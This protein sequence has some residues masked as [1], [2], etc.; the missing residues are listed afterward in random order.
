[1]LLYQ[2]KTAGDRTLVE[3]LSGV[4][5]LGDPR[6]EGDNPPIF[7]LIVDLDRFAA[8][9]AVLDVALGTGRQ[10]EQHGDHLAAVGAGEPFTGHDPLAAR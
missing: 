10:I 2:S 6:L 1:M 9:L 7:Y 5:L 8:D 4:C 3:G